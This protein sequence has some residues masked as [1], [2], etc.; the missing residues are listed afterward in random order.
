MGEENWNRSTRFSSVLRCFFDKIT[1]ESTAWRLGA[2][3][4][5]PASLLPAHVA[6]HADAAR[7]VSRTGP[8]LVVASED[9][10]GYEMHCCRPEVLSASQGV[11]EALQQLR[12]GEW[13]SH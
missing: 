7:A 4:S 12:A 9:I 2:L 8:G 5:T 11:L 13:V 1:E 10:D 3:E 6:S